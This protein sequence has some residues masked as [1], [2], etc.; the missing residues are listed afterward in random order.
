MYACAHSWLS[1]WSS[2]R[3][4]NCH[5]MDASLAYSQPWESG[6]A[7]LDGHI[8]TLTA[9][10]KKRIMLLWPK[11]CYFGWMN[12]Q[13]KCAR[14]LCGFV[15][16]FLYSL[17]H[18]SCWGPSTHVVSSVNEFVVHA[19]GAGDGPAGTAAARP[20]L[21]A[22]LMNL[23]KGRRYRKFDRSEILSRRSYFLGNFIAAL[24]FPRKYYCRQEIWSLTVLWKW[25]TSV[26][27]DC[28]ITYS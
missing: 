7:R 2:K 18:C 1:K 19:R 9:H 26:V 8:Y 15:K 21:E 20:M 28:S 11:N 13:L 24:L 17:E 12:E 25:A 22:K 4:W 23:I 10:S 3:L 16:A 14:Y 27:N 6:Y 5:L